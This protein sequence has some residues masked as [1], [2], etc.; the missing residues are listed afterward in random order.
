[1]DPPCSNQC[2][3]LDNQIKHENKLNNE[4]LLGGQGSRSNKHYQ[5]LEIASHMSL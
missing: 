4:D 1:M 3:N 5:T 2:Q